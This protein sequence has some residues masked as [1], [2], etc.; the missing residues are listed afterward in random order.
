MRTRCKNRSLSVSQGQI[1]LELVATVATVSDIVNSIVGC[2]TF[3]F[4]LSH[5][6]NFADLIC[7]E[8][9]FELLH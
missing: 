6:Q 5:L 7:R 4:I 3:D 2:L 9:T 8:T 1:D